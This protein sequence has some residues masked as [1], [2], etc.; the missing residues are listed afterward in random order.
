MNLSGLILVSYGG[1]GVVELDDGARLAC[2]YRRS[3]GRPCCGDRVT[4]QHAD[5]ESAIVVAIEP[6]RN[7]FARADA[8]QRR[9]VIAANLDRVVIVIAPAPQP[10]RDLVERYLV[11]VHSLG[12]EPVLV[13]N[14]ADL[15]D[16]ATL[17]PDSPLTHLDDY[18]ALGYTVLTTSCKASPGIGELEAA[19]ENRVSILVGQSGVGKSSLVNAVLPDLDLQT[20]ALSR[21]TGKGTHTTTTTIMYALPCGGRLIDSPGVW[22]YG[23]WRLDAAELVAGFPE[24][25]DA[26]ARCR[27]NDCRHAGEPGCAVADAVQ[28]GA[29]LPWRYAAYRR[30]LEQGDG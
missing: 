27:F 26:A 11:A 6:R 20:G 16:T 9:Q 10:S 18:R 17:G 4:V 21:V 3:V 24:F 25:R 7:E 30:L 19:L 23:L 2:K 22:E 15:M 8:R 13:L 12:I 29:I 14:K 28:H 5:G 1:R